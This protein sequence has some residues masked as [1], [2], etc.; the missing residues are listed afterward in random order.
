[1]DKVLCIGKNYLDHA[2]ELGDAIPDKPVLFIKPP[3]SV[4]QISKNTDPMHADLPQNRGQVHHEC[5]IVARLNA[6]AQI[7]HVTLGLD[8]T[9][10][11]LQAQQKK[12]GHPWEIAKV[13]KHAAL[14]GPWIPIEIFKN[15][16]DT[17]FELSIDQ[18]VKQKSFGN[19]MRL[20]PQECA[21]YAA[22]FFPIV[23]GDVLMTGTPEG[24]GPV[25]E[26]QVARLKWADKL[27]FSIR[28]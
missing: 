2:K 26:G 24:V 3:S 16:L 8:M 17:E 13:F 5:E 21:L 1:M 28:F 19:K 22:E 23:E 6:K 10:R 11:D 4:L 15:Y 18:V 7:T 20:S 25:Q 9:L 12:N 14:I 27:D